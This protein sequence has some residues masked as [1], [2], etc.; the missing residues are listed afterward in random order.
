MKIQLIWLETYGHIL[1]SVLDF[2]TPINNNLRRIMILSL[3]N[4]IYKQ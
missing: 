4:K 2:L 1:V 3:I